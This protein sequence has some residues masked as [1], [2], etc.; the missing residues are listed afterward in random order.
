MAKKDTVEGEVF[1]LETGKVEGGTAV[2]TGKTETNLA[3]IGGYDADDLGSGFEDFTIADLTI[4]FLAI[5]QS[6][7]PQVKEDKGTYIAGAKAGQFMN[8]VTQELFEGKTGVQIVPVHRK[9]HFI[10]WIPREQG[11][12][13][14]GDFSPSD[15]K[16]V[17]LRK[18][19]PFGKITIED[20]S[21][22][23]TSDAAN[24]KD[25]DTVDH[26]GNDLVETFTVYALIVK[27][28]GTYEP[29]AIS[30]AS[31]QI[32]H[33]KKWMTTARGIQIPVD[34]R[35]PITPPL[36]SHL[37]RART[38][39]TEKNN[40]DWYAWQIGFENGVA[41]K[42]RLEKTN[43]IFIAAKNF[44]AQV[45]A[46][47]VEIDRSGAVQEEESEESGEGGKF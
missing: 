1:D 37:Y 17:Q 32:K 24:Q 22:F 28:N 8:T 20:G 23:D 9:H 10:E 41:E 44:R 16:I 21:M 43:P 39:F 38:Q 45:M 18:G 11:G 25:E 15:Q 27:A 6:G 26:T 5:L 47:V 36:Y 7:S 2:A 29:M 30:F 19:V 33:Y 46:G 13:I 35:A 31:T 12:G 34:G 3:E 4:P 14:V 42:S 40:Y